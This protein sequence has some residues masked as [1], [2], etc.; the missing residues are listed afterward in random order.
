M[1]LPLP[2]LNYTVKQLIWIHNAQ[3][4]CDWKEDT[5]YDY[6]DEEWADPGTLDWVWSFEQNG[7]LNDT[8]TPSAYRT[9]AAFSVTPEFADDFKC[10]T[11]RQ[12]H[13]NLTC[14]I[15]SENFLSLLDDIGR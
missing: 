8:H 4:Y 13:K 3:Q 9:N 10:E 14:Q 11:G 5:G 2:R 7:L 6:T 15:A 12:M 1:E